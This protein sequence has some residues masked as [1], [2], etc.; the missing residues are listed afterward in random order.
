MIFSIITTTLE[1]L[2]ICIYIYIYV[3]GF[4]G[5]SAGKVKV[6]VSQSC[7]TLCDPTN[8][9]FCGNLQARILGWVS[10]SLLQGIKPRSPAL[11]VDSL[12]AEPQGKPLRICLQCKR[13]WFNSL[14]RKF[15]WRRDRL[16]TPIFLSF[17]DGKDRKHMIW[18]WYLD[19]EDLLEE[20]TATHSSILAWRIP[21]DRGAWQA[22]VHGLAK[23]QTLLSD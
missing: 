16:H 7:P 6:K 21:V 2:Y 20:D 5:S 19:L 12:P 17:P 9:T 4:L 22:T 15:P 13:P 1:V 11:Q 8:Y 18:V 10:L 14:V 23:S 3:Y